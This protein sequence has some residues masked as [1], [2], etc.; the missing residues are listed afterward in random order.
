M[1]EMVK[2][3]TTAKRVTVESLSFPLAPKIL[4]CTDV[5]GFRSWVRNVDL[6]FTPLVREI[7]AAQIILNFTGLLHQ[8]HQGVPAHP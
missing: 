5:D 7:A 3:R 6:D 8:P 2:I 4:E 1:S